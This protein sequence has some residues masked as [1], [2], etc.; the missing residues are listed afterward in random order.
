MGRNEEL[1]QAICRGDRK[2]A[3]AATEA[4]LGA[5]SDVEELLTGSLIPAM[6]NVGDEF[7]CGEAFVPEML[8]AAR[9]MQA[10]LD[11]IQ[12]SL[13]KAGHV[14]LGKVCIGTVQGDL[15]DIGKNLVA[16]MLRGTGYEVDD[17]GVNCPPE[18]FKTAVEQGARVVCCSALLTT[19]MP[20][21]KGVVEA[22]KA[23]DPQVKV[24]VGGAPVTREYADQIGADGYGASA[25]DATRVVERLLA[26]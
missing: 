23:L 9:A 25:S 20:A 3:L 15:H 2:A 6:K 26:G 16:M 18:K 1:Y 19:T 13:Q 14:S 7:A 4:A 12:P 24:V 10:C 8:V 22:V 21:M 17:L 11:R 5:G